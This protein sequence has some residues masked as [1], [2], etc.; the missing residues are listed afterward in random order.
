HYYAVDHT[1]S[2]LWNSATWEISKSLI[3]F[4]PTV[5]QGPDAWDKDEV[6]RQAIEIRSGKVLNEKILNFQKRAAEYPHEFRD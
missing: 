1:P 6:I 5:M 2:Y 4:L 3:P